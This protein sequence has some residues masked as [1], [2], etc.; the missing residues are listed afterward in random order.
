L[1]APPTRSIESK[2][3]PQ[4]R[5]RIRP[6]LTIK[7]IDADKNIARTLPATAFGAWKKSD[8]EPRTGF[9]EHR[10]CLIQPLP[11]RRPAR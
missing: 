3:P 9:V 10:F 2:R 6:I 11:L 1:S 5:V 8:I 4:T 7:H